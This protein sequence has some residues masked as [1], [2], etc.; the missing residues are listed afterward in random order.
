MPYLSENVDGAQKSNM[1]QGRKFVAESIL[2]CN[3][4]TGLRTVLLGCPH[5]W[6]LLDTSLYYSFQI[7]RTLFSSIVKLFSRLFYSIRPINSNFIFIV[8]LLSFKQA[9][10]INQCF[11]FFPPDKT[12]FY[13]IKIIWRKIPFLFLPCK[14]RQ[15]KT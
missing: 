13:Y 14:E 1:L 10:Y 9:N 12:Q 3:K 15:R 8:C 11:I 4:L 2:Y 6:I 5:D 7:F